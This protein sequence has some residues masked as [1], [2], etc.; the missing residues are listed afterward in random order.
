MKNQFIFLIA[1][2]AGILPAASQTAL[3]SPYQ[4]CEPASG[5]YYLYNVESGMWLQNN[6]RR[7]DHFTTRAELDTRGFDVEITPEGDGYRLNPRFRGNHSINGGNLYMDTGEAVTVWKINPVD[8]EGIS[9]ACTIESPAGKLG[10]GDNGFLSE[11]TETANVWQLVTREERIAAMSEAA[12]N[13]P[14]DVTWLVQG[15]NFAFN[16]ER[17]D[18]WNAHFDGGN[19]P[20]SGDGKVRCNRA[21]ES[22]NSTSFDLR[23]TITGIPNGTY[24]VSIQGYYRDGGDFATKVKEGTEVLRSLYFANDRSKPLMSTFAGGGAAQDDLHDLGVENKWAPNSLDNASAVFFNGEYQ[25]EPIEVEV[26]DG[27]L[28]LGITKASNDGQ[29]ADWTVFDNWK[30]E[31]L[32]DGGYTSPYNGSEVCEGDF[33]LYNVESGMWLQNNDRRRD[34]FTTR[35][36]LDTRGFDVEITPE[37][38]GYRLNPRFGGN[39]SINGSNLY[40]D[41]GDAVTVWNF[42]PAEG[43]RAKNAYIIESPHGKLGMGEDGYL[44]ENAPT[45]TTWQIV[46]R[47]ERMK[48]LSTATEENPAD[49]TWLVDCPNFGWTDE[50]YS[51]WN[52]HFEGGSNVVGGHD[53]VHCNTVHESWNSNVI[54]MQQTLT[55]LPNGTY[56]VSLQ[57]CYRDGGD[58]QGKYASSTEVLRTRYFANQT[59]KPLMSS[60]GGGA[61]AHDDIHDL[62]SAGKW[63]PN[64]M[65]NASAAFMNGEYRN[66]PILV[67]V[68]DGELRIGL[69]KPSNDGAEADWT[70]FDNWKVE[71][72]GSAIRT[73]EI[74]GALE[75]AIAEATAVA[76][77]GTDVMN[78]EIASAIETA[79]ALL[80]SQDLS[81]II[82]ITEQLNLQTD[83]I[84]KVANTVNVLRRTITIADGENPGDTYAEAV[85]A[86][87]SAIAEA[88]DPATL[89]NAL[90]TLRI[91]RK[92]NAADKQENL[93]AGN[94]PEKGEFYLYNVG[95]RQFLC[96]GSD[97]G[98]HA[99]LGFPG[100]PVTLDGSRGSFRIRTGLDNGSGDWLNHNG[101]C[102]TPDRD[103]WIFVQVE[104]KDYVYN[105]V[106]SSNRSAGMGYNPYARTDAGDGVS[107]YDTVGTNETDLESEN[108]QWMLVS[109]ADRDALLANATQE[110]PV[111]ASY[112]IRM[113]NFSQREYGNTTWN[114]ENGA[115]AYN[116]GSIDG[117]G[118]RR[119]DFVFSVPDA[120][121]AFEITQTLT[122]L[123]QGIY[124]VSVQGFY[125]DG[126]RE[127]I[128]AT[129]EEG[130]EPAL[131]ALLYANEKETP[132]PGITEGADMAPGFGWESKAG[133]LPDGCISAADYFQNGLYR[134]S[135]DVTVGNDGI[136]T[137]G[138]IKEK[139]VADDWLAFDNFRLAYLGEDPESGIAEVTGDQK[140]DTRI[141]TLSGIEVKGQLQPGIYIRG[142]RKIVI[143]STM[144]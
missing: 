93:F 45:N 33:Y 98:A 116:V 15:G 50:R 83:A 143:R 42:I 72:L 47:E 69:S 105:I 91:A 131:E 48:Y 10:M 103:S 76:E 11:N 107:F 5:T 97:W 68:T 119:S 96:G 74:I 12:L 110:N 111:D 9:N 75:E 100:I 4:G 43:S 29:G 84:K 35:A 39:H 51:S 139:V 44:S 77:N 65:N 113:P 37:G 57:G 59:S 117:R 55:G 53:K 61:D 67:A 52:A 133:E 36:E 140:T 99:A 32:G 14:I 92:A 94:E 135:F 18:A 23:Q 16:D 90:A 40:M 27:T 62:G 13:N 122:D 87:R 109:K 60:F 34:Q 78:S 124:R 137:I 2:C 73:D 85:E 102:D 80:E 141:F 127:Q 70:V 144:K 95:R 19:N 66:E 58:P 134:T 22:W 106:K 132:I 108:A 1:A 21:H 112:L 101:Y 25:N 142:G 129:A 28:T 20:V 88:T 64:S 8:T 125:R 7:T 82:T 26:T 71:Y 41:T 128:E 3:Q 115:W 89:N 104:G 120:G 54:D 136:L 46:T 130:K 17:Y 38:D 118:T 49:V 63:A 114:G 30:V 24:R 123:P 86:G 56:R 126:G 79:R 81:A 121:Q 138:I 6:D 31:Y